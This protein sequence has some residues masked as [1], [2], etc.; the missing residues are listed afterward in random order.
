MDGEL[1]ASTKTKDGKEITAEE[2]DKLYTQLGE[3]IDLSAII[4][5]IE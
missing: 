3:Q 5:E 4:H 2:Y 1:V